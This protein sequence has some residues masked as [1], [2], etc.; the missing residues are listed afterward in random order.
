MMRLL[1]LCLIM[2]SA[3]AA[4]ESALDALPVLHRGRVKPL[5]VA[6]EEL[7]LAVTGYARFGTV[8]DEAT[9]EG[10]GLAREQTWRATDFV[11]SLW[12]NPI[13]WQDRPFILVPLIAMQHELKLRGQWASPNE[14]RQHLT[15]LQGATMKRMRLNAGERILMSPMDL[16]AETLLQR[17]SEAEDLLGGHSVALL[18]VAGNP[19]QRAWVETNAHRLESDPNHPWRREVLQAVSTPHGAINDALLRADVWLTVGDLLLRPDQM[20][21]L[22]E[23][24]PWP[25]ASATACAALAVALH[26]GTDLEAP[27][28]ALTKA[29]HE[30][31]HQR[32]TT[33]RYPSTGL[34]QAELVY[35]QIRPFT[36]ASWLFLLAGVAAAIGMGKVK[37]ERQGRGWRRAA[38]LMTAVAVLIGVGG[39]TMRA[40]LSGWAA[41]T[42]LYETFVYV[43]LLVGVMGWWFSNR[44]GNRLYAVAGGIGAGLCMGLGEVLPPDM[45][46]GMSQLQPVLRSKFWLWTH[47]K[48]IVAS[49]AA[50]LLA[51]VLGNIVLTR[52]LMARREVTADEG[53]GLYRCLQVGVVLIAAGT[54]LGAV[55]A[56]QAWGRFWGW[57]PKEVWALVILLTYL[58]PLHLRF[59]GV[60]GPTGLAAWSVFGFLSVVMSWYGVNFLLGTGLHAY[61]FGN[62]G[63]MIVLP[64][65]AVQIIVTAITLVLIK[66][67]AAAK[68]A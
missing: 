41:V 9:R 59:V 32:D 25:T 66:R 52:A 27:A 46:R 42:N 38:T 31:A 26:A 24:A 45:G 39:L 33:T 62:G 18:P 64:L 49:Y 21:W 20:L 54:L 16:A 51:W 67:S 36:W 55:W 10:P 28:T 47:V 1:C 30:A 7:T 57:D 58:V 34:I 23:S 29:L 44:T 2:C 12:Q 60:V 6:A 68:P 48:V 63:Q 14:V 15:Q 35:R 3:A 40:A 8:R 61:A 11:L 65:C 17:F 50:F 22:P 56:D 53:R 13:A 19:A 43:G 4:V 5:A 37:N